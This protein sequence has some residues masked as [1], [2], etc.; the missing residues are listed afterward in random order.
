MAPSPP[1]R[2]LPMWLAAFALVAVGIAGFVAVQKRGQ[3]QQGRQLWQAMAAEA[4]RQL[5]AKARANFRAN[6]L[7]DL[8]IS[9]EPDG[10]V[11]ATPAFLSVSLRDA[12]TLEFD[13]DAVEL[14]RLNDAYFDKPQVFHR[15]GLTY[16]VTRK[17]KEL[18]TVLCHPY[19]TPEFVEEL[20]RAR[21]PS[22]N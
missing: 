8:R 17:G 19:F 20:R 5:E 22:D 11:V 21:L 1:L 2:G 14:K 9:V 3:E 12:A 7:A 4:K 18:R 15:G 6:V 13:A 16:T 10:T